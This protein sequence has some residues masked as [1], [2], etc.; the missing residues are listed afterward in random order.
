MKNTFKK[1]SILLT[2][3]CVSTISSLHAQTDEDQIQKGAYIARTGDCVAC[4]TALNGKKFAGG[5]SIKTPIGQ[6]FSTNITPDPDTGIGKYSFKDFD[7]AVRHGIRADG[8]TLY[9]AMPYPAFSRMTPDDMHALY[10]YM[11]HGVQPVKE[12]N[13]AVRIPWPL[14][15]RWPLALWRSFFAPEPKAFVPPKNME[16]DIARGAYLVTG[17]G[18]CGACHTP[19]GAGMQEKAYDET[20]GPDYL[21]GGGAI[22]NWIAPSLRNGPTGIGRWSENDLYLFLKSGRTNISGCFGGMADVVSW[23]TQYFSDD[24]LHAVAKYLKSLP[25]VPDSR[26]QYVYDPSTEK[27]LDSDKASQVAGAKVYLNQCAMCHKNDGAGVDR[28]FPPL[29]GNPTLL[30]ENPISV[31]HIVMDGGVLPPTSWAQSAVAMP[32]YKKLL[33][34]R[35]I[36]NVVNFIRTGWGNKAPANVTESDIRTIRAANSNLPLKGWND[37]GVGAATWGV[38]MP[39]PYGKGWNFSPQTHTG[40]DDAQ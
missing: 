1:F 11:M 10:A 23:S 14:S 24:D 33:S 12:S 37:L 22:D 6:I 36:A 13:K 29:A 2:L 9:P 25:S 16:P 30:S 28:M 26:S 5:L 20:G 39:Q 4:H 3:G 32:G 27:M 15:M 21:A 17:P 38:F 7:E 31:A 18:H 34:D 8:K 19:R 40:I 35:E